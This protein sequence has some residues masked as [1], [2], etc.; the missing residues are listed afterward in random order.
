[1][2][3]I[4]RNEYNSITAPIKPKTASTLLT[5]IHVSLAVFVLVHMP[6]CNCSDTHTRT[7][8]NY[9][10]TSTD[11]YYALLNTSTVSDA[12]CTPP[13]Y[14]HMHAERSDRSQHQS[15]RRCRVPTGSGLVVARSIHACSVCH[16]KARCT[17][18]WVAT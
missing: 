7:N 1:M 9:T 12:S 16:A 3:N 11:H 13:H 8:H 18:R 6:N 10:G 5:D 14:P 4:K 15:Q 2:R 17:S